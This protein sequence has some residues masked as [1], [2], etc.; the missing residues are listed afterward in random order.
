MNKYFSTGDRIR[1]IRKSKKLS[2]EQLALTAGITTAYLGQIERSE[3]NP[4]VAVI[5]KICL[6]LDISLSEFFGSE[7]IPSDSLDAVSRQILI[8]LNNRTEKEKKII[9]QVIKQVLKLS[10]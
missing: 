8:Q 10:S 9:L 7:E 2:Q 4:T 5:E 1:A 6:S 3:K